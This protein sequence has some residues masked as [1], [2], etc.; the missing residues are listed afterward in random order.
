[1]LRQMP[2][3]GRH[4]NQ[5][6]SMNH[7]FPRIA[8]ALLAGLVVACSASAPMPTEQ[9]PPLAAGQVLTTSASIRF[10]DIE[11][12]CWTIVTASGRRYEPVNLGAAFRTDGLQV[13]VVLR[14]APDWA[15]ICQT[16]P[17]VSIDSISSQ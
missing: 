3:A 12:G 10:V 16:A 11:G 6:V 5:K 8:A 7:P 13:R 1:M 9:T 4:P 2:Q 15:S 14:D 17:L